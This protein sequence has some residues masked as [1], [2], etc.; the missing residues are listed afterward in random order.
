M[1][2]QLDVLGVELGRKPVAKEVERQAIQLGDMKKCSTCAELVK[3][4]A[5]KCRFCGEALAA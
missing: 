1:L 4:E 5:V 3:A 2:D